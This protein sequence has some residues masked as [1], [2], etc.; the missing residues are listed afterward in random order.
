MDKEEYSLYEYLDENG[1]FDYEKYRESQIIGNK[2]KLKKNWANENNISFLSEY[3]K[4]IIPSPKF[5]ICHGSRRG[6]EQKWF[7]ENLRC[8]VI[9]TEIS[10]TAKD[11]P[12]T[13]QWDFHETKPEWIDNIDFIYSNSFDHTYDPEKCLNAWM[14]CLHDKGICIIEHTSKHEGDGHELDP[15]GAKLTAMPYLITI[16]GNGRYGVRQILS[17]PELYNKF[18]HHSFIVI[19]NF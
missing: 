3:I 7:R 13:I 4:T 10:E 18:T 12:N 11:F 5:G 6:L 8:K 16:W 14:S 15:F 19:Q 17:A 9:G 1:N 2:R